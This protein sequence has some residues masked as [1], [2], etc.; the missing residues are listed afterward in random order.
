MWASGHAQRARQGAHA[1]PSAST[2]V[3]AAPTAASHRVPLALRH[4]IHVRDTTARA[5][6]LIARPTASL[7]PPLLGCAPNPLSLLAVPLL[8]FP[9]LCACIQDALDGS[10]RLG[11][12]LQLK[13]LR[14]YLAQLTPWPTAAKGVSPRIAPTLVHPCAAP[15]RLADAELHTPV[16]AGCQGP[17]DSPPAPASTSQRQRTTRTMNHSAPG[18]LRTPLNT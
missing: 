2:R 7:A 12:P 8:S 13:P 14:I 5:V 11:P 15:P 3:P 6:Q 9:F 16:P 10:T 1:H 4:T 17:P 18:L